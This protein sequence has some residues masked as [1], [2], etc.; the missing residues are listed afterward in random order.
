MM[1]LIVTLS[2]SRPAQSSVLFGINLPS[3]QLMPPKLVTMSQIKL[4]M[5]AI[6]NPLNIFT[7]VHIPKG[8]FGGAYKTA[9]CE[10]HFGPA[11][12]KV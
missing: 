10:E 4:E 5:G 12:L 6:K 8:F 11:S 2:T 1:Y 9:K 3:W 7:Y